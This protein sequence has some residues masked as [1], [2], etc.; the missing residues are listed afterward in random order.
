[1]PRNPSPAFTGREEVCELLHA[2]CLLPGKLHTQRQQKRFVIH[3]LGGSGKTQ[4]CLKFA[5]DHREEWA[6]P[7]WSRSLRIVT[8]PQVLGDLLAGREQRR[9]LGTR[10]PASR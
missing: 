3:G 5:Q 10:L 7:T 9:E 1:M 2:R 4:V 8:V 6:H